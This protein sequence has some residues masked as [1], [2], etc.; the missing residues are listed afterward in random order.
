MNTCDKQHNFPAFTWQLSPFHQANN[1][2][3]SYITNKS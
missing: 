3:Q 2:C 1:L